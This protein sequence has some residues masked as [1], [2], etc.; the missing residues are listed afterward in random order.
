MT[1][2]RV[3]PL[4]DRYVVREVASSATAG[5]LVVLAIFLVTRL[6]S[7]LS[8]AAVG[9]LP[10][11]VVASLLGLRTLMALPSLLPAVLYLGVLLAI[12]RL[13]R[14]RELLAMESVGLGPARLDRAVLGFALCAA[15]GVALLAFA[16]RPWAAARFY[17]VRDRAIAA[18]GLDDI[19]PGI[20]Y[21]LHSPGHE[22]V[23]AESRSATEPEYLENVFVQRRTASGIAVFSARRAVESRDASGAMRLL[24][25]QD[26]VQYDL[27]PD[28]ERH[29]V[30]EFERLAM[31]L[32]VVPPDPDVTLEK[33]LSAR[34]L[35][36]A[37]DPESIAELQWR[38]A[39]PVSA[40]LLCL[41]AVPLGRT[42]PR[43]GRAARV[44]LAAILYVA[45]RTLLATAKSWVADGAL[46]PAPGLWLVHGACLLTALALARGRRMVAA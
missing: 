18:S 40:V 5:F 17:E 10:G 2:L 39:M 30:T 43:H 20:F 14:D 9:S 41:L 29:V 8:D 4:L 19:T 32:P 28:G 23:F 16:G 45:Y 11:S 21:E 12:N 46:P 27:Q 1:E 13:S 3:V 6:S 34:A 15:V 44:F 42:D 33:S 36:T 24:I 35:A 38:S 7:L 25:L 22:V 31:Q 37:R 26:G